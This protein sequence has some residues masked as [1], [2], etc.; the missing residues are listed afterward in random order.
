MSDDDACHIW[1]TE[2]NEL[3]RIRGLV[4]EPRRD[5]RVPPI[6]RCCAGQDSVGMI[7][8][9]CLDIK[10]KHGLRISIVAGRHDMLAEA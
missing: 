9:H 2:G 1:V 6:G 3:L 4:E 7:F 8:R 5:P 10:D